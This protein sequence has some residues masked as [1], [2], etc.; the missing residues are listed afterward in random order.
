MEKATKT[1]D[2]RRFLFWWTIG[3]VGAKWRCCGYDRQSSEQIRHHINPPVVLFHRI[4]RKQ[5]K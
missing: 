1:A 5:T 3:I 2:L 4:K